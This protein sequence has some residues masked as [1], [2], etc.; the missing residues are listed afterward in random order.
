[1]NT[2]SAVN[3]EYISIDELEKRTGIDFF[4]NL[5]DDLEDEAEK[6]VSTSYWNVSTSKVKATFDI[7]REMANNAPLREEMDANFMES[8]FDGIRRANSMQA[9]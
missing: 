3:I 8:C 2:A 1:L 9:R 7:E 6:S 5:R 4:C